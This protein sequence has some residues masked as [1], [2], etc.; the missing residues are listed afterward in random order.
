MCFAAAVVAEPQAAMAADPL[1]PELRGAADMCGQVQAVMWS[2]VH[3]PISSCRE[4]SSAA[5]STGAS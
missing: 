5:C 4:M 1:P 2:A 3:A